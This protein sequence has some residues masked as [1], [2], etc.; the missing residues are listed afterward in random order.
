MSKGKRNMGKYIMVSMLYKKEVLL[1]IM[2][3]TIIKIPITI[4]AGKC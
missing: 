4:N 2:M 1:M 3:R